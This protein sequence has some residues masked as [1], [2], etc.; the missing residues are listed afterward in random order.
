MLRAGSHAE[1]GAFVAGAVHEQHVGVQVFYGGEERPEQRA[2]NAAEFAG[3][4]DVQAD[5][6]RVRQQFRDWA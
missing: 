6:T 1:D 3:G 4:H 5:V 2:R